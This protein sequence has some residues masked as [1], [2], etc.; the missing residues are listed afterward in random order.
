VAKVSLAAL[1]LLH[2]FVFN[3]VP[4]RDPFFLSPFIALLARPKKKRGRG[5]PL[6]CIFIASSLTLEFNAVQQ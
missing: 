6:R 2:P 3:F 5:T 4:R 1:M